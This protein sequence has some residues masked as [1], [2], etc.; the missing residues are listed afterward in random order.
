MADLP[1]RI[2]IIYDRVTKWGGAE[3]VLLALHD[4][5]PTA[6]LFTSVYSPKKTSWAKVFPQIV[7][8]FLQHFSFIVNHHEYFPWLMPL[9][10]ESLNFN[11][12]DAVI[13]VTSAEAK[14][15]I[16]SPA[17]FHLCYCLTPTRYLW[18][19]QKSYASQTGLLAKPLFRY[20]KEVDQITSQ[21]PDTY[22]AI[23]DV[24][25]DRIKNY[26]HR[27]SVVI[28]PPVDVT[29]FT[30]SFPAQWDPKLGIHVT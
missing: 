6:P 1:Q 2:A 23:S 14:D 29:K 12:Y 28:Y 21:R 5:F 22:V 4:L 25:H 30:P 24:V 11:D 19:H 15:I 9:A 8:T 16:T 13:S 18:S 26:Y 7:P 20:M 27:D 10:F 17:T 3:Q